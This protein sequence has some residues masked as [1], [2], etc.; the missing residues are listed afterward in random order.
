MKLLTA[1]LSL[2][3]G[4]CMAATATNHDAEA[5]NRIFDAI[6]LILK[7]FNSLIPALVLLVGTVLAIYSRLIVKHQKVA[8]VE[9]QAIS[10]KVDGLTAAAIQT[11]GDAGFVQGAAS[12][13]GPA[14]AKE[15][16]AQAKTEALDVIATAATEAK[17][18]LNEAKTHTEENP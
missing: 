13:V 11:A 9:R 2:L 5:I 17:S 12:T 6:D 4:V 8:A 10:D 15:V 16:L 3:A 7:R 18:V 1:L 14:A